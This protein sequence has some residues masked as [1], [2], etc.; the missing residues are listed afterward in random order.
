MGDI[1]NELP[2]ISQGKEGVSKEI[3]HKIAHFDVSGLWQSMKDEDKIA[4]LLFADR[5]IHPKREDAHK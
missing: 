1:G 2:H 4:V 5:L 3:A